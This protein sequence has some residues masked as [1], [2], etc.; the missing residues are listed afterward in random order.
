MPSK[1][2]P[3]EGL[4]RPLRRPRGSWIRATHRD[5]APAFAIDSHLSVPERALLC[6]LARGRRSVVEIGSYLGAS[7][8][9]FAA[10]VKK[11]GAG[12]EVVCIDTWDN[13]SWDNDTWDNDSWDNDSMSEG[14]RDTWDEFQGN[15]GAYREFLRP[16][17]GLSTEVIDEVRALTDRID[18]LFIDGDH[19][20]EGVRADWEAYG[21]MLG[22]GSVVAFHDIRW[23]EGVRRVVGEQV[24]PRVSRQGRLP[25]LWWGSLAVVP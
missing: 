18:L 16:V 14:R 7:A 3:C 15:T 6:R 2:A 13:D 24:S 4:R 5:L 1:F 11:D 10:S 22:P 12:G 23:A 19:S 17:R 20:Y 9:C 25:N 21:S 8:C